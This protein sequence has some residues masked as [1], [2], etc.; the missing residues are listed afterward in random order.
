MRYPLRIQI[1]TITIRTNTRCVL[2][3]S[4]PSPCA[5]HVPERWNSTP[6]ASSAN[7]IAHS[8]HQQKKCAPLDTRSKRLQLR[9]Y[10]Q[11]ALQTSQGKGRQPNEQLGS[12]CPNHPRNYTLTWGQKQREQGD[13]RGEDVV[14]LIYPILLSRLL[15]FEKGD[16]IINS[17][18][19]QSN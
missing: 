17:K 16:V 13:L 15:N 2:I 6:A 3:R 5:Q 4:M 9:V 10:T 19:L 11:R 18:M 7:A 8:V 1:D 12:P 14:S